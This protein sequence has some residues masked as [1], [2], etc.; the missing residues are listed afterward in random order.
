M[1]HIKAHYYR[2][3]PTINPTGVVPLGPAVDFSVP[4]GRG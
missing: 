2:S 4:H 3:H 1:D